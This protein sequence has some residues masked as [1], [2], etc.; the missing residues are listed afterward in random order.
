MLSYMRIIN[1][2]NQK[3]KDD[4]IYFIL[5]KINLKRWIFPEKGVSLSS[6]VSICPERLVF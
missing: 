2:C 4:D 5:N 3:K 6:C 1:V